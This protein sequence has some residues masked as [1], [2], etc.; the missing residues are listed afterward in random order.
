MS[1]FDCTMRLAR[2]DTIG[3]VTPLWHVLHTK[4]RQEKLL[5]TTLTDM[6]IQYYLPLVRRVRYYGRRK[7]LVEMPLFP[8]YVFLRGS[9]DD[10]FRAD[11]SRR[12]AQIIAVSDQNQIEWEIANLRLALARLAPLEPYPYI[13][14]GMRVEVRSGP[15]RGLQGYVLQRRK[16]DRLILRVNSFGKCAS[17][18]I[19]GSL[20]E[21]ID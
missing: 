4:S 1:A 15:F 2:A 16:L 6:G 13:S 20:L 10:A 17:L 11:R 5:A 19:D 18:E 14:E 7:V 3:E 12:I 8:G 9:R 21:P